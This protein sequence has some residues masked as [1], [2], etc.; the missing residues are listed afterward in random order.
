MQIFFHSR[1][2]L[3]DINGVKVRGYDNDGTN[4]ICISINGFG[5]ENGGGKILPT[6]KEIDDMIFLLEELKKEIISKGGDKYVKQHNDSVIDYEFSMLKRNENENQEESYNRT[7]GYI[8]VIRSQ[9]L[10]KIGRALCPFSRIKRYI[11]ENPFGIK[12]IIQKKVDNYIAVE[13]KLLKRFKEKQYRGEWFRLNKK[14][15]K[16]IRQNI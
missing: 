6:I 5:D 3:K 7:E 12:V 1:P 14:D 16:W 15:I 11:T 9:N 13:Q 10:Y 8:Y 4:D 2:K